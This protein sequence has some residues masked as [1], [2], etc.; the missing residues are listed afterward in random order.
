MAKKKDWAELYRGCRFADGYPGRLERANVYVDILHDLPDREGGLARTLTH[1]DQVVDL[2]SHRNA[3]V[4]GCGPKPHT[5]RFLAE[6]GFNAIGIEPVASFA[7]LGREYVG[8]KAAIVEGTAERVPVPDSSQH[9]IF[10]ESVLEHVDSPRKSLEEMY[11]ILVPGGLVYIST[12]NRYHISLTGKNGEFNVPFFNWFPPAVKESFVFQQLHYNP[13][14][15]NYSLRPAVHWF[16]YAD[17]CKIGRDAG[18]ADFYSLVDM[19]P[20]DSEGSRLKGRWGGKLR[21]ELL[22]QGKH[23]PWVRALALIH[24]GGLIVMRKR[25]DEGEGGTGA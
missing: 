4:I 6:R 8:D 20:P 12:T 3:V 14:L 5:V 16:S 2:A 19:I 15:A 1:L 18:F 7:A 10:C 22:M 9:I 25:S 24:F 21:R 11:R 13:A 23:S 17:L